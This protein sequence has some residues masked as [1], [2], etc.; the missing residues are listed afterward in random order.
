L[1]RQGFYTEVGVQKGKRAEGHK[2]R[3]E[4]K[5]IRQKEQKGTED[6]PPRQ[7]VTKKGSNHGFSRIFTD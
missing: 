6:S 2:G 7:E 3:N 5:G 4:Q 1:G